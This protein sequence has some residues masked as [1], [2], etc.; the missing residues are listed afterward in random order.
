LFT[1]SADF[2]PGPGVF[3]LTSA[4]STDIFVS[5]L[6]PA[7]KLTINKQCPDFAFPGTQITC[8]ITVN[9]TLATANNV[10]VTDTLPAQLSFVPGSISATNGFTCAVAGKTLTCSK[11]T[12][13]VASPATV[14]TFKATLASNLQPGASFSNTA[15]VTAG[16]SASQPSDTE[17]IQVPGCTISGSGAIQGTPGN[18]VICGSAG[19]D[20][21]HG[22]GGDDK[23]FGQ[24]GADN[25]QGDSGNDLIFGGDG[26][27][28]LQGA[29]GN[30]KIF[31]GNGNDIMSGGNGNDALVGEAG[32]DTANGGAGTD[33][34]SA[35]SAAACP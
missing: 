7:P 33:S 23:I 18:D 2:D 1:G 10:V 26:N 32:T 20:S 34:C 14:I 35:E 8:T 21:I 30:D 11:A 25:I 16:N 24:G 27:D 28:N 5:K 13:P 15:K 31:G 29:D 12:V 4:G 17:V 6:G 22:L 3:N 9:I 19:N